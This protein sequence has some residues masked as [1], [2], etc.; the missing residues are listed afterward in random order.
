LASPRRHECT[1]QTAAPFRCGEAAILRLDFLGLF[2]RLVPQGR[3]LLQIILLDLL[4]FFRRN[5]QACDGFERRAQAL[6]HGFNSLLHGL[7][8]RHVHHRLRQFARLA[9]PLLERVLGKIRQAGSVELF[10]ARDLKGRSVG[11][12]FPGSVRRLGISGAGGGM[13]CSIRGTGRA[14]CLISGLLAGFLAA[15]VGLAGERRGSLLAD[16]S[17][18]TALAGRLGGGLVAG[19]AG[20]FADSLDG[21]CHRLA[22]GGRFDRS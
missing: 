18:G 14:A 6:A 19:L 2:Q 9:Q 12:S 16:R 10:E 4:E 3:C 21:L 11:G 20:C 8:G 15:A 5:R 1:G 22:D 17:L 7:E 13:R